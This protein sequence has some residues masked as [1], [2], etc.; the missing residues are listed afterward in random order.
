MQMRPSWAWLL[1]ELGKS[2]PEMAQSC[3]FA[4]VTEPRRDVKVTFGTNRAAA[5]AERTRGAVRRQL[6]LW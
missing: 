3:W 4:R 2:A 1:L 5:L 6:P